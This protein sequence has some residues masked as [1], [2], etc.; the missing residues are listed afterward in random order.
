LASGEHTIKTSHEKIMI[1]SSPV[2]A[3]AKVKKEIIQLTEE[4]KLLN[5][6]AIVA[7]LKEIVPEYISKNSIFENLDKT[8]TS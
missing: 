2:I 5:D 6:H 1:A 8:S 7:V 3:Y 4:N